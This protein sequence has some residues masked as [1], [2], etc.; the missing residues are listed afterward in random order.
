[1]LAA[2]LL[3]KKR[4]GAALSR[5][6][7]RFL[8]D[9][10][11][12]GSVTDYQ[13]SALAMAVCFQGMEPEEL[14]FFTQAMLESGET[15]PRIESD[16]P[17]VDKH[18]TGGLGDKVS[19]ILAP[20]LAACDLQ[21]PMI[22]GRGLGLTGGTLD[23]LE[24]IEGFRTQLS[25]EESSRVLAEAGLFIVGASE[26]IAPADRQLYA[27][28][29][30]TGTVDSIELITSSILSKKLAANLDALVLDVKV[31]RGAFMQTLREASTLAESLVRVGRQAGLATFA[32]LSDMDQPLG[33]AV[34]NAIEVN[35]AVATLEGNGPAEL[36]QLTIELGV[37]LLRAT[38]LA[39][40]DQ[41]AESRLS[42]ELDGGAAR[43]RFERMV[44]AQGGQPRFP[45]PLARSQI[46]YAK[47]SGYVT[48]VDCGRIGELIITMGGGRRTKKDTIDASVGMSVHV[49][50]GDQVER[51][52]PLITLHSRRRFDDCELADLAA[53]I[54]ID[55]CRLERRAVVLNTVP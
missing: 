22:S 28:R 52:Q 33:S 7:I 45:L 46:V 31:G 29:D 32:I 34:G 53:A 50:I 24:A 12:R 5:E 26:R 48:G 20:L 2:T 19:L 38:G 8:I 41:Q 35:E 6:E 15:L 49:R 40:D 21:V 51:E 37:R 27:I 10:F 23:K 14:S 55:E 25:I 13:M 54:E 11:C 43:E 17:R 42:R 47:R 4:A 36:R 1:M 3:R 39:A 9:G 16:R 18:S 44:V 30:V